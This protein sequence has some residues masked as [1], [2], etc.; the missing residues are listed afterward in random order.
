MEQIDALADKVIAQHTALLAPRPYLV[1]I[2]GIPA[3]GKSSLAARVSQRIN[4]RLCKE[5]CIC[6]GLDGWH[7][8]R[9]VLDTFPNPR[10]AHARRGA[11][12]TFDAE[13]FVAFVKLLRH[14]YLN[15]RGAPLP[16]FLAPSFSHAAKDPQRDAIR[17]EPWHTIVIIEGLYCNLNVPP[18]EQVAACWDMRWLLDIT[19]DTARERLIRRHVE[20]G[21][22]KNADEAALQA[23]KND[24]PNGEWIY[25]HTVTP[26]E[27]IYVAEG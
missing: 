26:I 9:S 15:Q 17:V 4:E 23:D 1:G 3:S 22:A 8:S 12:F 24:L 13:A 16:V 21:I 19:M 2:S 7:H 20:A 27:R 25:A 10:E 5:T 18:W 6:I 14:G 11:A